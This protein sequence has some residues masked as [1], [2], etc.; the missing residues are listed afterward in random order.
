MPYVKCKAIH[1]GMKQRLQYILD[2]DK[3]EGL[4][5]CD[6]HNCLTNAEDA[7]LN[8]K[9]IYENFT[10]HKFEEPIPEKGKAR[11]KLLH[12]VQSFSPDDNVTPELAH[13]MGKAWIRKSF[14]DNVQ[15]VIA[16]HVDKAHIHNHVIINVYGIDGYKYNSNKKTLARIREHSDR[17]C[18]AFGIQPI[19]NNRHQGMSYKEWD[20]HRKGTSFKEKIRREID[21]LVL[22]CRNYDHLRAT[23]EEKGY[24]FRCKPEESIR[25]P[26]QKYF[27]HLRTLGAAYT[28][29]AIESRI[30]FR[31][32]LGKASHEDAYNKGHELE[33]R[34]CD[35]IS[36]A[37]KLIVERKMKGEKKNESLPYL[38]HNDRDVFQL[39][40]Q[41]I[42]INRFSLYSIHAVNTKIKTVTKERDKLTSELNDILKEQRRVTD[43]LNQ[44]EIWCELNGKRD[45]SIGEKLKLK[46]AT[47]TLARHGYEFPSNAWMLK[48]EKEKLDREVASL[49][50]DLENKN[51]LITA[52]HEIVDTFHEI[53]D[54]KKGDYV[55]RLY[56]RNKII[57]EPEVKEAEKEKPTVPEPKPPVQDTPKPTPPAPKPAVQNTPKPAAPTPKPAVQ[58]TPKPVE[59]V[60][61][62]PVQNIPKPVV[63]EPKSPVHDTPKQDKPEQETQV[64]HK[65]RGRR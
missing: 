34:Y 35:A 58:T 28:I 61:K 1:T 50:F 23:L 3:T 47:M 48:S 40:A 45:A 31:D 14:G 24:E 36:R 26:S 12:Y 32:D 17:V 44:Y 6:S 13:R 59:P 56:L 20:A 11:V 8:M 4:F 63:P 42:I 60:P 7:Y 27:T 16:T 55:E 62:P 54:R 30:E 33:I 43:L 49:R 37:A 46:M 29:S 18:L 52:L 19:M 25:A 64:Q 9:F 22:C 41:L 38:P 57:E 10:H 51:N 15:A 2:P 65:S 5:Y 21:T 53:D 39:S